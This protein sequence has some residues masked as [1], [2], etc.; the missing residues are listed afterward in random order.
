MDREDVLPTP[1]T[2]TPLPTVLAERY[3]LDHSLG[4]GG[5]GE[6]FEATDLT[7]HRSVAV[8]L[9]SP[10]LVQ[11]EPARARFLREARALAQVNSPNVVAVYDAGEDAERPYLVMELV[12]GTTLERELVGSGRV[13][14]ARAVA[15]ATDIASGLAAAHE[16]G[17]VHRDVKPGNVLLDRSGRARL[18]DFGIARSL[19]ESADRLTQTGSVMGTLRYMAPEQLTGG[20]IG[21]RTDLY[22]LGAVLH[23]ALTGEPPFPAGSPVG[24]V[25]AQRAGAPTVP[26]VDPTL[27]AVVRACLAYDP[28][29]RP[30]H[31]GAIADALRAWLAGGPSA[32]ATQTMARPVLAPVA[33]ARAPGGRRLAPALIAAVVL[34]ALVVVTLLAFGGPT[35]GIPNVGASPTPSTAPTPS[36]TPDWLPGLLD[37]LAQA[38]GADAQPPDVSGLTEREAKQ[39]FDDAIAVCDEGKPGKGK[40]RGPGG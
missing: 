3:R 31:A 20:E 29:D 28:A 18:A 27:A 32:A 22:G 25:E 39:A 6:V 40:G 2:G 16:R 23:E 38:C 35:V 5:M 19:A 10:S 37:E 36:P 8:K 26:A 7:L 17:I 21:P 24:L 12:E 34:S 14:A 30:I 11:D 4:N 15:I 13:E 9:M 1:P 33:R